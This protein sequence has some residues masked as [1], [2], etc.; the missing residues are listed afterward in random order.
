MNKCA[1]CL[2]K[3]ANKTNTHYLTD[4]LLRSNFAVNG[5]CKREKG[6]YYDVS[7]DTSSMSFG[8]Q[9]G[10]SPEVIK[11][12]L[13]REPNEK[14]I[15][16]AKYNPYSADYVFC[17][18]CEKL[19]CEIEEPF[20]EKI[21]PKLTMG[22]LTDNFIEL[23]ESRIIRLFFILQFWRSHVCNTDIKL[24]EEISECF[25]KIILGYKNCNDFDLKQ[26]PM[27]LTY[28][29]TEEDNNHS[30]HFSGVASGKNPYVIFLNDFIVQLYDSNDDV[31]FE[32]L[33][34]INE[35]DSYKD[36]IN[37]NESLFKIKIINES[38]WKE[39]ETNY[40]LTIKKPKIIEVFLRV[41]LCTL[42]YC[43][44]QYDVNDF[45][46]YFEKHNHLCSFSEEYLIDE[47]KSYI[48]EKFNAR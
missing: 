48:A 32:E 42:H 47:S 43:P 5:I 9:R 34:G 25:R 38:E 10:T 33:F 16:A 40:F 30:A 21:L 15:E 37:F 26:Y 41:F 12:R 13:G 14:E 11:E 1:L 6:T 24:G 22:K 3:E 45:L 23:N 8:F 19:F 44:S 7:S 46:I 18:D 35:K 20:T 36:F 4:A 27:S 28:I 39:I 29:K 31:K 2:N 17:S